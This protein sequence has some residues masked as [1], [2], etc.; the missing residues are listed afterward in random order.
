MSLHPATPAEKLGRS[1][2][3]SIK[4]GNYSESVDRLDEIE[5]KWDANCIDRVSPTRTASI[6]RMDLMER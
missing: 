5:N 1:L 6:N 4:C 2:W 3:L